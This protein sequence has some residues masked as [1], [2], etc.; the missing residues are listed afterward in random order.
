MEGLGRTLWSLSPQGPSQRRA[1]RRAL[2]RLLFHLC[3]VYMF[4]PEARRRN[5]LENGQELSRRPQSRFRPGR[6][7]PQD[8][9]HLFFF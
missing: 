2:P 6:P 5:R 8:L 1:A 9:L 4:V 7:F 3:E